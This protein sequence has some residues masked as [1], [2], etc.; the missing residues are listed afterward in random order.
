MN[1]S[2]DV[3]RHLPSVDRLLKEKAAEQLAKQ[4]PRDLVV[5]A[6]R[7]ALEDARSEM[8]AGAPL[9]EVGAL[10]ETATQRL[11]G[12]FRPSLRPVINATGVIIHTNLGRAPLS[13]EALRAVL[14]VA[15]GYSNLEYRLEEGLRG[16]RHEH[17]SELLRRITGAEDAIAVNNNA[18]AMLLTLSTLA[19]GREVIV[20]R[21]QAVEIGGGF[22]IP[23]VLR[24]SGAKLVEVATTNRTYLRDYEEAITD[25]TALLLHVHPSNFRVAGF[26]HSTSIDELVSLGRQRR[27]PVVDDLGSGSFLD[28]ARYG[29]QHE[30]MVQERIEAGVDLVCFSGDKLLGGPQAGLIAGKTR[31]VEQLRRHPLARAIRVDKMTIAALAATL[32]HYLLGDAERKVPVWRMIAMPLEEIEARASRLV[33]RLRRSGL[34]A[35]L[36]PGL[37]T[38]GGGSLP[39]ETLPTRLIAIA[40]GPDGPAPMELAARLRRMDPPVVARLERSLLLL[41]L[42]TVRPEE[43]RVVADHLLEIFHEGGKG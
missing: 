8:R 42:R 23:D 36:V 39:G 31:Y 25:E 2:H 15:G 28:S 22:R 13:E 11:E 27:I 20:S 5:Q 24:Q 43:D 19:Q 21:G 6:L 16:S 26:V 10:L 4:Y 1:E 32:R 9:P 29:L 12:A 40:S 34:A 18:G 33:R 41:D 35:E 17:V 38:I 37:S 30:P 3:L 14:Q 7:D